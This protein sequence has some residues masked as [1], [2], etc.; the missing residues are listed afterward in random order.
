MRRGQ[1]KERVPLTKRE[2]QIRK[3]EE[4]ANRGE[5]VW[6]MSPFEFFLP[7][8]F[9]CSYETGVSVDHRLFPSP[10]HNFLIE[11]NNSIKMK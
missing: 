7:S 9:Y 1:K 4:L 11:T 5:R 2:E 10:R 3:A 8:N 6:G